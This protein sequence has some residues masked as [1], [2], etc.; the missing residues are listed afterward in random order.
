LPPR[1]IP[2]LLLAA[3]AAPALAEEDYASPDRP[4]IAD[5]SAVVGAGRFQ[6]EAGLQDALGDEGGV[7]DR[8]LSTPLLLRLGLSDRFEARVESEGHVWERA[9]DPAAGV[10]HAEGWAPVSVG[11]KYRLREGAGVI[12]RLFPASG[13][14]GFGTGHVTGDVRLAADWDLGHGLSLNPNLGLAR[15]E[16]D[17]GRAFAAGLFAMTFSYAPSQR[18]SLFVDTAEQVPEVK[19]GRASA[20][21]DGGLA[22]MLNRDVQVDLSVGTGVAGLTPPHPFFGAGISK[23][24]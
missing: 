11:F 3:I 12:V 17:Q 15:Y 18:F 13:S 9:S 24:F 20:V 4:G 6:V 19:D 7:H 10:V 5:S 8:Q 16:D 21:V 2:I 22:W 14:G 1:A 23:R